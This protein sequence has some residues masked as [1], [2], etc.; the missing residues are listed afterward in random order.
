M[1]NDK[2]DARL[3]ELKAK[4]L[5]FSEVSQ[6]MGISRGSAIGR[7]Q[8]L[9]GNVYP[10]RVKR[11]VKRDEEAKRKKELKA[12]VKAEREARIVASMLGKIA[13]GARK[14][15]AIRQAVK[16]GASYRAIGSG[17]GFSKQ[18]V[19]QILTPD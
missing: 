13:A 16:A 10:W 6:R 9:Q 11:R 2:R 14:E 7:F 8:R 3:I 5:S 19:H 18:R 17:L 12:L 1:W 15:S 4:G